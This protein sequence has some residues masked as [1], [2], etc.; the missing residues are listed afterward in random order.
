MT[1]SGCMRRRSRYPRANPV[2][3]ALDT[4]LPAWTSPPQVRSALPA[5]S[6]PK[7][8]GRMSRPRGPN[9]VRQSSQ[10][11]PESQE[12][13]GSAQRKRIELSPPR[14]VSPTSVRRGAARDLR[15]P[16]RERGKSPHCKGHTARAVPLRALTHRPA[17]RTGTESVQN[18]QRDAANGVHLVNP[19][20]KDLRY[21]SRKSGRW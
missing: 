17:V 19:I 16:G 13:R 4:I 21:A 5:N 8:E 18:S 14:L 2:A 3:K 7:A 1:R 6:E 15:C 10:M 20:I 11:R 12:R 9:M